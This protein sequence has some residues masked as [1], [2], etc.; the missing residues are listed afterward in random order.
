MNK[1]FDYVENKRWFTLPNFVKQNLGGFTLIELLVSVAI[2]LV[3]TGILVPNY[4]SIVG[5]FSLLRAT[6]QMAQDLRRAQE[7]SASAHE[8]SNGIVPPGYGIY[9]E[10][11]DENYILYADNDGDEEYKID[12]DA[13]IQIIELDNIYI[14]NAPLSFLSVNFKGP[15]PTT[16]ITNDLD[17]MIITLA[18]RA[19]I[20]KEKKVIVYKTGLI[21]VE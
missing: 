20:T 3:M 21:Y 15:E 19:D 8:L 7:M 4:Y 14:K 2:I 1:Q 18:L 16:K 10:E 6:H 12:K 13:V 11:N 9:L 5:Q 17:S